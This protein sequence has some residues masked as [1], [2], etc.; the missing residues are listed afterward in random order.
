MIIRQAH[1]EDALQIGEVH[2]KAWKQAYRN[3]FPR[4]F[5][6]ADSPE[7][8]TAEF[9]NSLPD[10]QGSYLLMTENK[11]ILGIARLLRHSGETEL[12]SLY[13]PEE[14]RGRGYG[15][16][17]L[18]HLKSGQDSRIILWVLETNRRARAFYEKNGFV[19]TGRSRTIRRGADFIQL[20]YEWI[21]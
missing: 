19:P 5:I 9:L 10:P 3:V 13:L 11:Q 21:R 18:D 16:Q 14:Y 1:P 12:L 20:E 17:L 7:K 15:R 2:S 8:R 6:E 4:E